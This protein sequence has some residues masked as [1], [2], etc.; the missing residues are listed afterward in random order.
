MLCIFLTGTTL[1]VVP[2]HPHP[3]GWGL[4]VFPLHLRHRRKTNVYN[5]W[6][7]LSIDAGWALSPEAIAR[8]NELKGQ[9]EKLDAYQMLETMPDQPEFFLITSS[10]F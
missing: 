10:K 1:W 2:C 9:I 4:G 3:E 7:R 5:K 6:A 8:T